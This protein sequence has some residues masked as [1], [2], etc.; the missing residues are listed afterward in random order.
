MVVKYH[1]NTAKKANEDVRELVFLVSEEKIQ[2]IYH[3]DDASI[4]SSTRE[5]VKP[6]NWQEKG[7]IFLWSPDMHQT[8]QVRGRHAR[9][10]E[11]HATPQ[12]MNEADLSHMSVLA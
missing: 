12:C 8:F 11:Q 3:T 7:A 4:A 10:S 6:H 9:G 2:M 1:R 5:F